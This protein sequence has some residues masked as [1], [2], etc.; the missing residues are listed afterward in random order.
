MSV[1]VKFILFIAIA[2]AMIVIAK[3]DVLLTAKEI[4]RMGYTKGFD[5]C[6]EGIKELAKERRKENKE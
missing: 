6:I 3:L 2:S 5:D 4:Y 1:E